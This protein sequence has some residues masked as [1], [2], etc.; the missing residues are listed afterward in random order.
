MNNPPNPTP[1]PI[2]PAPAGTPTPA[3]DR[4]IIA[5]AVLLVRW[6]LSD[7]ATAIAA[8]LKAEKNEKGKDKP[9]ATSRV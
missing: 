7:E 1:A 4:R 8:R 5:A 6:L 2:G 9:H 3:D